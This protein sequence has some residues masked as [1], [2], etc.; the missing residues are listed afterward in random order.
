[1]KRL[2]LIALSLITLLLMVACAP[3][4]VTMQETFPKM[5]QNPPASIL[6]LPPVNKST[7]ADA[8]EY[9]ACSLAEAVGQKGYYTL[10]VEAV[11]TVLKDEGMYDTENMTPT[12]LSNMKKKFGADAVL[13]TSIEQWEKSW[14]L[15]SGSLTIKANFVLLNTANADTLW[16]FTTKTKVKLESQ[17]DNIF[18]AAIE[19]AVKTAVEDYFPNCLKANIMTMDQTMPYGKHH[20]EFNK[21]GE[22]T[23]PANKYGEIEI[24]K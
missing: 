17:S 2:L 5:Y 11:F 14:A 20:P 13:Y 3:Q 9:F 18:A 10:P 4:V 12:V 24:T 1:M 22:K 16:S 23:I 8:K 15:V 7:A 21:D 19:S 6:I